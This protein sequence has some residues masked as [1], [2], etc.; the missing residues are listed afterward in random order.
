MFKHVFS[1][2][3]RIRRLEYGLTAIAY[4]GVCLFLDVMEG[5]VPPVLNLI[6]LPLIWI[7]LAQGAKRCHD[8]GKS[9]FWQIIPFY[10][11]VMIFQVGTGELNEYGYPPVRNAEEEKRSLESEIQSIGE[12]R[13]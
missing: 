7:M 11:L 9:G 1:F 6:V 4:L 2:N 10:F 5:E 8:I 3:G 13:K 12:Q